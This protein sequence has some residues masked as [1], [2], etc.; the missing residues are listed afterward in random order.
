[1]PFAFSGWWGS[2]IGV[3]RVAEGPDRMQNVEY[4]AELRDLSLA[5][6]IARS[7]G[8]RNAGE[9]VQRDT[10]YKVAN[11]RLK[12]RETQ[13]LPT[14]FIL[15]ERPNRTMAKIS[16]YTIFSEKEAAER[17]GQTPL[18]EWLVVAKVRE[19][20]LLGNTRIHLDRVEKL[21]NFLEF[22]CVVSPEHNVARC[23]ET[24]ASLKEM[25]GPA[26]GE[27][28][29]VSYSDMLAVDAE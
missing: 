12:K 29:A 28:I 4:K 16:R 9:L 8:A 18:P 21:G 2:T 27:A 6:S 20:Y 26:L 14:E 13:G 17:Y 5:R 23:H 10:Y 1:M 11:G 7:A 25:F 3:G 15:Y 24:L 22:E 19:L